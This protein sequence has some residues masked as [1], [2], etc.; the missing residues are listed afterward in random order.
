M[1]ALPNYTKQEMQQTID[2]LA[3]GGCTHISAYM[4]KIEKGTPFYKA[5]PQGLPSEDETADYYL[6][7]VQEVLKYGYEQYEISNFAKN[8]YESRHNL[9]YWNCEDYIGFGPSA[10]SSMGKNRYAIN[11][12]LKTY[13]IKNMKSEHVGTVTHE[14]FIMLSLRLSKGLSLNK[15]QNEW[16]KTFTINQIKFCEK[17]QQEKL[18]VFDGQTLKLTPKGMLL[19]NSILCE[20]L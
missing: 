6:Q 3:Q 5:L 13:I 9:I 8:G 20:L 12:D 19:Q 16:G 1:L 14:D 2:M 18:A 7:F 15:L 4:L 17:L 10:H 11:K